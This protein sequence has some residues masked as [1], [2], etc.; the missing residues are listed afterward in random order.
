MITMQKFKKLKPDLIFLDYTYGKSLQEI[1]VNYELTIED[2]T[3]VLFAITKLGLKKIL[4][5]YENFKR[6]IVFFQKNP[7]QYCTDIALKYKISRQT[8]LG[9]LKIYD[10]KVKGK[11]QKQ[12]L[13]L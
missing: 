5:S 11:N 4:Q 1:S 3:E 13:S 9:W 2:V 8:I 6:K 10:K 12:K 7:S